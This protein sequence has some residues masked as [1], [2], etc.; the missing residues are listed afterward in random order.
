MALIGWPWTLTQDG[1]LGSVPSEWLQQTIHQLTG[2]LERVDTGQGS[3]AVEE[4]RLEVAVIVNASDEREALQAG[5]A[6]IRTAL[7]AAGNST[8]GWSLDWLWCSPL[9]GSPEEGVVA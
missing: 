3:V 6:I 8:E 1:N 9:S 2:E 7:H 5:G 4:G